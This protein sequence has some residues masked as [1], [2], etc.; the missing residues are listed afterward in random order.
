MPMWPELLKSIRI[1]LLTSLSSEEQRDSSVL[2][3]GKPTSQ[4][5]IEVASLLRNSRETQFEIAFLKEVTPIDGTTTKTHKAILSLCPRGIMTFN[6]DKA[7]E[8]SFRKNVWKIILPDNDQMLNEVL[9][10]QFT[11]QFLLKAHGTID[12]PDSMVLTYESYRNL[13]VKHPAYRA[14][15]Q[16][17]LTN[18]NLIIIGFGGEDPDFEMFIDSILAQFGSPIHRHIIIRRE[19][20][21]S[22]FSILLKRRYGIDTLSIEDYGDISRI[23][24]DATCLA[25][26]KLSEVL[27][28]C[29]N[30]ETEIRTYAHK[31]LAGLSKP[32]KELASSVLRKRIKG[33]TD[34]SK[35]S[36]LVYSPG[37]VGLIDQKNWHFLM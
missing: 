2:L 36:K 3:R 4:R 11:S 23:L 20:K 19:K 13:F 6:Y 9:Q 21:P 32:G 27:E 31:Q 1:E 30:P 16:N 26:P 17:I 10:G 24:F 8:A 34:P 35:L 15:V 25:G 37:K 12:K 29:L 33:E 28:N 18:F 22:A 14:F 5:L 7:H